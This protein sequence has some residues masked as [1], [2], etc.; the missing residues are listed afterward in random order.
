MT[1]STKS[2]A[3]EK[4]SAPSS[5][6]RPSA[7]RMTNKPE[8]PKEKPSPE[9]EPKADDAEVEAEKQ[10]V[11]LDRSEQRQ[12][13]ERTSLPARLVHEVVRRQGIEELERPAL[14]LMWSGV[15]AGLAIGL[16]V[17]GMGMLRVELPASPWRPFLMAFG[18]SFGF[19][20]VILGR[21]QLF[22]ESTVSAIIPLATHPTA[23]SFARTGRLWGI[24]LAS[25][26]VGTL[27]FAAYVYSGGLGD[28]E[29][30]SA[31]VEVS[32]AITTRSPSEIFLS[33]IP[34][35][36][37]IATL[38]WVLPSAEGQKLMIII[39]VTSIIEL[40]HF[41]HIVAGSAE[42]WIMVLTGKL[43][44]GAAFGGFA[45]P[46]LAGNIVGGSALFGVLAHAQVRHEIITPAV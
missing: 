23:K 46:A 28:R 22:T 6:K 40:C 11:P 39:L 30:T 27:A 33:A 31:L 41:S 43:T 3:E 15:A 14:S 19:V 17:L 24:V 34:A 42:M 16:S 29:L 36:F 18:Y 44:L 9:P 1:G 7:A 8:E 35:G 45:V 26:F 37:L 20:V 10:K 4:K 12:V 38:V 5:A 32:L 13:K 21:M 2:P 25:N